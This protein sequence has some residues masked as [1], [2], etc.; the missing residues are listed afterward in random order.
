MQ[1]DAFGR[2][3]EAGIINPLAAILEDRNTS[4][5]CRGEPVACRCPATTCFLFYPPDAHPI[6]VRTT[7]A[8]WVTNTTPTSVCGGRLSEPA[9]GAPACGVREERQQVENEDVVLWYT[10]GA[11]H[12]VRRGAGDAVKYIG[13][14]LLPHGFFDG[15]PS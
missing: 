7:T 11:H 12:A 5:E 14:H 15:N 2:E 1:G 4:A 6:S 3:S 13:F 9:P 10:M 8:P